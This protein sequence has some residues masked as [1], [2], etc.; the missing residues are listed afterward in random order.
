MRAC[1]L[2]AVY[3]TLREGQYNHEIYLKGERPVRRGSVELPFRMYANDE[4]P[5]IVPSNERHPIW[6][7]VFRVDELK[8]R[9]L[10]A[11]EIP[12]GYRRETMR[13]ENFDIEAEIYVYPAPPPPGFQLV[14]NGDWNA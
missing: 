9:E 1:R 6:V 12:Y 4:Y 14:E 10:D 11:L 13:L 2:V 5:M 7:E 3:G 8:L